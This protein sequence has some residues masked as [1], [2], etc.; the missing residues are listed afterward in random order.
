MSE[1]R[2]LLPSDPAFQQASLGLVR[3]T[4]IRS[5]EDFD[6]PTTS[7]AATHHS[8]KNTSRPGDTEA[9]LHIDNTGEAAAAEEDE[10]DEEEEEE[11]IAVTIGGQFV[12]R[13]PPN[14]LDPG[15]E[16]DFAGDV[17]QLR[18][19]HPNEPWDKLD[20]H[21]VAM[22]RKAFFEMTKEQR[23]FFMYGMLCVMDGGEV[24][25]SKRLQAA[26]RQKSRVMFCFN[27]TTPISR[28]LFLA[29]YGISK[30]YL[31]TLRQHIRDTGFKS[32]EHGNKRRKLK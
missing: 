2:V 31:D 23:D 27:M 32:R 28:D 9:I 24:V 19:L 4:T 12:N 21:E 25:K 15:Q 1:H 22:R 6:E 13:A 11:A 18:R 10:D 7:S 14:H 5:R 30:K 8:L 29:I 16:F 26:R 17:E 20:A 3:L